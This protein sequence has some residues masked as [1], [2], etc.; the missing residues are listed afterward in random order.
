MRHLWGSF[1]CPSLE[2]KVWHSETLF[3]VL[4]QQS[5]SAAEHVTA[6]T[7]AYK[8]K[9]DGNVHLDQTGT[10]ACSSIDGFSTRCGCWIKYASSIVGD[11]H[12]GHYRYMAKASSTDLQITDDRA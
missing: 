6:V 7:V 5:C 11:A 8:N 2:S 4:N 9:V 1:Y 12:H 10:K 3:R